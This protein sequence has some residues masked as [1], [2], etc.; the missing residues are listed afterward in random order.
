LELEVEDFESM[1][2]SSNYVDEQIEEAVPEG[3]AHYVHVVGTVLH[4]HP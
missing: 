3:L 2:D 1:S 4:S